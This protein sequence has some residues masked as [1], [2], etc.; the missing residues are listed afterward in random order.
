MEFTN[1][2]TF[3]SSDA[4]KLAQTSADFFPKILHFDEKGFELSF[5]R[6][7]YLH[8]AVHKPFLRLV[9]MI[10]PVI[11]IVSPFKRFFF[12]SSNGSSKKRVFTF[13]LS[14][15]EPAGAQLNL[16]FESVG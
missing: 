4:S 11:S 5:L 3:F 15:R 16:A 7:E 8:P 9:E 13:Q 10:K 1:R 2:K 12:R 14:A 6:R